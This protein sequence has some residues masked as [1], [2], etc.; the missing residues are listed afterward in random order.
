MKRK[1]SEYKYYFL[2]GL[3]SIYILTV[4][5]MREKEDENLVNKYR[6]L[7]FEKQRARSENN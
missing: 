5:V 1:K 6:D 4:L 2:L 3:I 7:T